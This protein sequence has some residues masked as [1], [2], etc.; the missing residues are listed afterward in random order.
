[1]GVT[2]TAVEE[3]VRRLVSA[4]QVKSLVLKIRRIIATF[5]AEEVML[6]DFCQW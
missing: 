1:M 2:T 4:L 3:G 5:T 6:T